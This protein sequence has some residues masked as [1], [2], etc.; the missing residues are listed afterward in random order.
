MDIYDHKFS[1]IHLQ[2]K[3]D[4]F[5]DHFEEYI[6][7]ITKTI[8]KSRIKLC[9]AFARQRI[10][11]CAPSLEEMLPDEEKEK[12]RNAS[13]HPVYVRVNT[14]LAEPKSVLETLESNGFEFVNALP[15]EC[16]ETKKVCCR[17]ENYQ[18]LFMFPNHV[19]D[20]IYC[21]DLAMQFHII[22]QVENICVTNVMRPK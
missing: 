7:D 16:D 5:D 15:K 19:K 10:E 13:Q 20:D 2:R 18:D 3:C 8:Y 1:G 4:F 9:A 22:P 11:F 14:L 12:R 21:M 6:D 17:D